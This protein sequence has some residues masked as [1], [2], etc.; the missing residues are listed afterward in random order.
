MELSPQG[1][2]KTSRLPS[3]SERDEGE[4]IATFGH[5]RLIQKLDKKLHKQLEII[6][7]SPD[8][9]L[10]AN[11]RCKRFLRESP[12]LRLDCKISPRGP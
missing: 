9:R 2:M 10:A 4:L 1:R 3:G 12:L 5:A 11:E 8:D 6:G 7:S